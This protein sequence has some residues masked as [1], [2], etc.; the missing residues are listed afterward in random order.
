MG[1]DD[2]K[3]ERHHTGRPYD[4]AQY[5]GVLFYGRL[6]PFLELNLQHVAGIV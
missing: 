3:K 6:H 5:D 1:E 2:R 4:V